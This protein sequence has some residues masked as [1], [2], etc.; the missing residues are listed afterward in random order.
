[1]YQNKDF[2][3][4]QKRFTERKALRQV[5]NLKTTVVLMAGL[6]VML[7]VLTLSNHRAYISAQRECNK[8]FEQYVYMCNKADSLQQHIEIMECDAWFAN[9]LPSERP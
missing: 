9:C 5:N 4:I 6:I 8:R 1:M 7:T 3:K 2:Q